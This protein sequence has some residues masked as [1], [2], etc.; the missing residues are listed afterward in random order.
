MPI[1]QPKQID[2][3]PSPRLP[4]FSPGLYTEATDRGAGAQ[5]RGQDGSN[6]R[7]HNGLPQTLGGGVEETLA[8]YTIQGVARN[9]FE[10]QSLDGQDWIAI[11]TNSKLLLVNNGT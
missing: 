10:W 1:T 7:F 2:V 5:G 6:I 8:G 9:V 3:V 11:G 4:T